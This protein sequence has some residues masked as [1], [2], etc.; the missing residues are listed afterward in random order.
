MRSNGVGT[1]FAFDLLLEKFD[2]AR[3]LATYWGRVE[4]VTMKGFA[5]LRE[6]LKD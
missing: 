1:L 5:F 3:R 2:T 6:M 4:K